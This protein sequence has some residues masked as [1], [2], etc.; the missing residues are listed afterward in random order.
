MADRIYLGRLAT[1]QSRVFPES[2]SSFNEPH[3]GG[4]VPF[5]MVREVLEQPK[6]EMINGSLWISRDDVWVKIDPDGSI[7]V[8]A[9]GA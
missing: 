5:E 9:S 7:E 1:V 8:G 3:A 2:A 6:V 4:L